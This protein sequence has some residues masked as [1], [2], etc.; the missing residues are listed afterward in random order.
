VNPANSDRD[1]HYTMPRPGHDVVEALLRFG[2]RF[3]AGSPSREWGNQVGAVEA[4][5]SG[6]LKTQSD[7]LQCLEK[8]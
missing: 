1:H 3:R 7:A 6:G 5:S 2:E 8:Q 4:R